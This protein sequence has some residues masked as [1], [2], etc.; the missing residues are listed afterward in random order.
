MQYYIPFLNPRAKSK[1]G[2]FRRSQRSLLLYQ[3]H[4]STL[5]YLPAEFGLRFEENELDR[6]QGNERILIYG[7]L[8]RL[9]TD[10]PTSH[11]LVTIFT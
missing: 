8:A 7:Q 5:Y 2:Q 1:G 3:Q 9:L 10:L 6:L 11:F 4:I